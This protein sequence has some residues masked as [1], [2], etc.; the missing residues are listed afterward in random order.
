MND[1]NALYDKAAAYGVRFEGELV[2]QDYHRTVDHTTI[3]PADYLQEKGGRITRLRLLTEP[4]FPFYDVSY[5]HGTLPDGRIVPVDIYTGQIPR[6]NTMR[7]L[8]DLAKREGFNA[9]RIGL[10]D[11]GNWSILY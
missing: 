2:G 5:C 1:I 10:L 7:Y 11:R 9:K 4:G 8:V 3:Y 6:R